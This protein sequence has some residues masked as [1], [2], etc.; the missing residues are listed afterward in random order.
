MGPSLVLS[1]FTCIPPWALS[2]LPFY[3]SLELGDWSPVT[4]TR[5]T[6]SG[7]GAESF[8]CKPTMSMGG[9]QA[10][11]RLCRHTVPFALWKSLGQSSIPRVEVDRFDVVIEQVTGLKLAGFVECAWG[12]VGACVGDGGMGHAGGLHLVHGVE[13]DGLAQS[14]AAAGPDA[15]RRVQAGR[16]FRYPARS[17]RTISRRRGRLPYINR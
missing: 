9:T 12:F 5:G 1:V 11:L 14:A 2:R 13:H 8:Q 15:C 6:G 10:R 3:S 16:C 17:A 7:L 4:S